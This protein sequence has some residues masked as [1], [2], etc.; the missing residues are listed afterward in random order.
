MQSSLEEQPCETL[1]T[2]LFT[3][4]R[5]ALP[6]ACVL[7]LD[8]AHR[9]TRWRGARTGLG[10][11]SSCLPMQNARVPSHQA[12]L[13]CFAKLKSKESF[14]LRISCCFCS[15][16]GGVWISIFSCPHFL[17]SLTFMN[18]RCLSLWA[19]EGHR[20]ETRG[21][22]CAAL[23]PGEVVQGTRH[24]DGSSACLPDRRC[25]PSHGMLGYRG[26]CCGVLQP[27]TGVWGCCWVCGC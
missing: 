22:P 12:G 1:G 24:R 8:K 14:R 23:C 5:E 27:L 6:H 21:D 17:S 25:L 9:S 3:S 26:C 10:V 4:A 20:G 19:S 2:A 11:R 16:T 7:L 13:K 15:L 18:F